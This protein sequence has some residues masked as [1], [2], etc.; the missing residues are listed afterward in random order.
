MGINDPELLLISMR[1]TE[2]N[3]R[4]RVTTCVQ[5]LLRVGKAHSRAS[6]HWSGI[7]AT[8]VTL[9]G[10]FYSF[11]L[12]GNLGSQSH[13]CICEEWIG[14]PV[15]CISPSW[16]S[17]LHVSIPPGQPALSDFQACCPVQTR[18]ELGE[19]TRSVVWNSN[20]VSI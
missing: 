2:N 7:S 13:R 18:G 9:L 6:C 16:A 8:A 17:S 14:P 20:S 11:V 19:I 12:L 15:H 4:S 5:S 10:I 1:Y 3:I